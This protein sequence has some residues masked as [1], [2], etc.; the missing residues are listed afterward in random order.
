MEYIEI[1]EN[2]RP[3]DCEVFPKSKTICYGGGNPITK[4]IKTVTDPIH[5][6]GPAIT[7]NI[8]SPN[9]EALTPNIPEFN[10][11]IQNMNLTPSQGNLDALSSFGENVTGALEKNIGQDSALGQNLQA[12]LGGLREGIDHNIKQVGIGGQ[13]IGSMLQK[14]FN[15]P[16]SGG[17]GDS[18][19]GGGAM[20]PS[21]GGLARLGASKLQQK[22]AGMGR[23]QT[24]LTKG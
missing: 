15:P 5:Q 21:S 16:R 9:F 12:N 22:K 20:G 4:A 2:N 11:P 24:Y 14:L 3:W 19:G 13:M 17:G 18:G 6:A 10:D 7:K 23:R 8:P 1:L